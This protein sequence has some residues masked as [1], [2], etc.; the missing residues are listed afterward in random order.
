M[1]LYSQGNHLLESGVLWSY[2][3]ELSLK[4]GLHQIAALFSGVPPIHD[5]EGYLVLTEDT[6]TITGDTN[7]VIALGDIEQIY[8]GFDAQYPRNFIKNFGLFCQPL[9]IKTNNGI[10]ADTIY[11][12]T[13]YSFSG[14]SR[15][16][17]LFNLLRGLLS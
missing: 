15:N 7:L 10:K 13:D 17:Q 11:L 16:Q 9:R 12:I 6:L 14:T 4:S 1:T 5:H 3:H 8:V 2:E